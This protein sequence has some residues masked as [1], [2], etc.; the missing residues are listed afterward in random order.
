MLVYTVKIIL[1]F[2]KKASL[3]K[4]FKKMLFLNNLDVKEKITFK[5]G[6]KVDNRQYFT[7]HSGEFIKSAAG[8][9]NI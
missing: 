2:V 7:E 4:D 8:L 5:L 9:L 1:N 6:S 3:N